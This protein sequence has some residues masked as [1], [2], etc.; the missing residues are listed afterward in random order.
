MLVEKIY[1]IVKT[2]LEKSVEGV[3]GVVV[4]APIIP[5]AVIKHVVDTIDITPAQLYGLVVSG[6]KPFAQLGV[7]EQIIYNTA[8]I[9]IRELA[10]LIDSREDEKATKPKA[11]K[12]KLAENGW[13]QT[14]N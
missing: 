14:N 2:V 5:A 7:K 3:K 4:E 8:V 1:W 12:W 11:R 9:V 13:E 6:G 10:G